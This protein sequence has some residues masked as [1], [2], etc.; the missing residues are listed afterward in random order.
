[1]PGPVS[2]ESNLLAAGTRIRLTMWCGLA[3]L[4][5]VTGGAFFFVGTTPGSLEAP[6]SEPRDAPSAPPSRNE[7]A[8]PPSIDAMRA[9]PVSGSLSVRLDL[10]ALPGT[11]RL[12]EPHFVLRD[13]SNPNEV[14]LSGTAL[15][16]IPR[17][18]P[19]T[20]TVH[21]KNDG[22]KS[23]TTSILIDQDVRPEIVVTAS[24]ANLVKL[25][26][27][28]RGGGDPPSSLRVSVWVEETV[29]CC[30]MRAMPWQGT[31][32]YAPETRFEGL[33][34]S[35]GRYR[36]SVGAVGY[37]TEWAPWQSFRE[38][39]ENS[40]RVELAPDDLALG[41]LMV[42]VI[43]GASGAPL[44]NASITI[45]ESTYEVPGRR[46]RVRI[47]KWYRARGAWMPRLNGADPD[48]VPEVHTAKTDEGG[49]ATVDVRSGHQYAIAVCAAGKAGAWSEAE[50]PP[51][52]RATEVQLLLT[53]Q[54]II[55][56]SVVWSTGDPSM[57]G[58][59]D[60][61]YVELSDD[62][63]V[64]VFDLRGSQRFEFGELR[65]GDYLLTA[66]GSA[67]TNRGQVQAVELIS[68][69][70]HINAGEL[71]RCDLRIGN[72]AGGGAIV[73]VVGGI[74][75]DG[76][77][78]SVVRTP[79]GVRVT[80]PAARCLVTVG[81][82]FTFGG[83]PEGSHVLTALGRRRDGRGFGI[84]VEQ[85][86]V[87]D[88]ATVSVTLRPKGNQ[89][90]LLARDPVAPQRQVVVRSLTE[91]PQLSAVF[92]RP[93]TLLVGGTERT[94]CIG[95]PDGLVRISSAPSGAIHQEVAL[96]GMSVI[97]LD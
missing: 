2:R 51:G 74:P 48:F 5:I 63:S 62:R 90:E 23:M 43:D 22:W 52:G 81:G 19:R 21:S 66:W 60:V 89:V 29:G 91:D 44:E 7:N 68:Q 4:C 95:L 3:V 6:E 75:T 1:M 10:L 70:V 20:V 80:K 97:V 15:A 92:E 83:V 17:E 34:I 73:G 53:D 94:V 72:A 45:V 49:T 39:A 40:V 93:P 88:S 36:L 64:E 96:P 71:R 86:S 32:P 8:W 12:S 56:G 28:Q 38:G 65:P 78:W 31:L 11:V 84:A 69:R 47:D 67:Q 27:A 79:S 54:S 18:P 58:V 26:I 9:E 61:T 24:S 87:H 14:A 77:E 42:A 59:A 55:S 13:P 25:E 35:A 50:G 30:P 41:R 16:H 82:E 76:W 57:H 85:V 37:Q 33:P 46:E